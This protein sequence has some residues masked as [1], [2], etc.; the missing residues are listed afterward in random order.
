[1]QNPTRT[2]AEA[3]DRIAEH[4]DLQW[5][6][7]VRGP[8]R[9]LTEGL[10]LSAGM[11]CADLGCGTGVDTLDMAQRVAPTEVVAVDCSLA[12]LE[13]LARRAQH[14]GLH[15]TACHQGAEEFIATAHTGSYE[16]LSLRFCLGYFDWPSVLARLPPLLAAGGRV[17]I[18]TIL[19]SSAPQA[20]ET[21]QGM[22][23]ELCLPQAPLT[24]LDSLEQP[25]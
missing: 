17:G 3:Y 12:M 4:Y 21:Y 23:Q 5:S 14:A 13:A 15:I 1:M 16:V 18:L 9:R 20:Y 19:S 24:A 2:I 22:M 8:Q 25:T 11:R 10:G 7:R 6:A